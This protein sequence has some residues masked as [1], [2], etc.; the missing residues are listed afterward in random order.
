M[1][2]KMGM[3]VLLFSV[4]LATVV[5]VV[6]SFSSAGEEESASQ[7][8]SVDPVESEAVEE[9]AQFNP[10]VKLEI[11]DKPAKKKKETKKEKTKKEK[12]IRKKKAPSPPPPAP[13]PVP[14]APIT[15]PVVPQASWPQPSVQEV[16]A[17]EAPRYYTPPRD[18][19]LSL[20]V[21]AIGLYDVPVINSSDPA[22]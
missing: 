21:S 7:V 6:V 22:A 9:E 14:E 5:A 12:K 3:G 16:A 20:T 10:G 17:T 8:A 19:A 11:D 18:S 4:V 13:A 15:L 2:L 1:F